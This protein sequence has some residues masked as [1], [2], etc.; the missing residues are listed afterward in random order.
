MRF[1][2]IEKKKRTGGKYYILVVSYGKLKNLLGRY[3]SKKAALAAKEKY[4]KLY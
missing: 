2:I 1:K 4:E 3:K